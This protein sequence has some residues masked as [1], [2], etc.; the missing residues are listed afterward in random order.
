MSGG[1]RSSSA[2]TASNSTW[3]GGAQSVITAGVDVSSDEQMT[4]ST[5]R[6][7]SAPQRFIETWV[8]AVLGFASLSKLDGILPAGFW[9]CENLFESFFHNGGNSSLP[10]R[11][12]L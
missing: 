4:I 3:G 6:M 11:L 7:R 2:D 5:P 9:V 10:S 8:D 1:S 12:W